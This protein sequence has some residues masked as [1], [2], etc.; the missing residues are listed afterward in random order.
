MRSRVL[1]GGR[2]VNATP[3]KRSKHSTMDQSE[4]NHSVGV[5]D[6]ESWEGWDE[7]PKDMA[8][9]RESRKERLRIMEYELRQAKNEAIR[10]AE[11][12]LKVIARAAALR[13]LNRR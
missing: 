3:A 1:I 7:K 4:W 5:T 11:E 8:W 10:V 9:V 12:R 13:V 6:C 2:V